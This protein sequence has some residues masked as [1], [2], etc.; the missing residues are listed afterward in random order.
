MKMIFKYS[1]V[2][3]L[4]TSCSLFSFAKKKKKVTKKTT[5]S[6]TNTASPVSIANDKE[7]NWLTV[8]QVE[9]QLK[10]KP[11]KVYI[12]VYTDWCGWCKVMDKKTFSHPE[13]IKYLN[14][15][16][17]CVH[18]N[19]EKTDNVTLHGKVY[20]IVGGTNELASQ[21]MRGQMSYPTSLMFD[22]DFINPQ[23]IPGYIDVPQFEM[24]AKYIKEN[25]TKT[26][27]FDQYQKAFKATWV[28]L[29]K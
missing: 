2:L 10:I 15:H 26:I 29:I 1:I 27:P 14:E 28:Q 23:P 4:L 24:I 11:K 19:A 20:K 3:L 18:F 7:I 25:K 21:W 13:V 17:Y 12:D 8:E 9:A 5:T 22:E 16:F 6:I